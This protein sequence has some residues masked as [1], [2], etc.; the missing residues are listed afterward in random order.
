MELDAGPDHILREL[1]NI[2][3]TYDKTSRIFTLCLENRFRAEAAS[4]AK[5]GRIL[6]VGSG[7][8]SMVK[9]VKK[10]YRD[11]YIV[12]LEPLPRFLKILSRLN[13]D[14]GIDIVQGYIEYAPFR[15]DA[16]DTVIAG[17][18]LRDV[19]SLSRA[20]ASMIHMSRRR[21]VILDFWRPSSLL[22]LLVEV[23]YIAAVMPLVAAA[24][25]RHFKHHLVIV[26][27]LLRVPPLEKFIHMLSK[28]GSLRIRCWALCI[29]FNIVVELPTRGSDLIAVN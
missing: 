18:M 2:A 17:F 21:I 8:G 28:V 3:E 26:E 15:Q 6:D 29:V 22:L 24:A 9:H 25:P 27:T 7:S 4:A 5:P 12:A 10:L 19:M 16:F 20:I 13:I 11:S 1:N 14:P 23:I